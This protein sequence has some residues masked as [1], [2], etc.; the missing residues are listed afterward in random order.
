MIVRPSGGVV[1]IRFVLCLAAAF[2]AAAYAP[3]RAEERPFERRDYESYFSTG[4]FATWSP[5]YDSDGVME[6]VRNKGSQVSGRYILELATRA[7]DASPNYDTGSRFPY[8]KIESD[9]DDRLTWDERRKLYVYD[10]TEKEL[11][12]RT[13]RVWESHD[14]KAALSATDVDRGLLMAFYRHAD[15]RAGRDPDEEDKAFRDEIVGTW[16][17]ACAYVREENFEVECTSSNETSGRV[18]NVF[19]RRTDLVG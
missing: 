16:T 12:S 15:K 2:G 19:F 5:F 14:M 4:S 1:G 9:I 11:R 8:Y 18:E 6:F 13:W 17:W 7:F 3:A 10:Y